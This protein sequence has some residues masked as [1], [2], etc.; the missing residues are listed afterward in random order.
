MNTTCA[1]FCQVKL[2]YTDGALRRIAQ[3]AIV[4]NTGARGLRSI[5]ETLLTEAMYQVGLFQF[6]YSSVRESAV[7][8]RAFCS[9]L[10]TLQSLPTLL[11]KIELSKG[12]KCMFLSISRDGTEYCFSTW[13]ASA[14]RYRILS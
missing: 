2:H 3:K 5:M 4:K 14:A 7:M 12:I 6:T 11:E 9:V 1:W 8:L 13:M 10:S